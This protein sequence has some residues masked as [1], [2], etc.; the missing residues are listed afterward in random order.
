MTGDVGRMT[1]R[2]ALVGTMAMAAGLAGGAVAQAAPRGPVDPPVPGQ[3]PKNAAAPAVVTESTSTLPPLAKGEQAYSVFNADLS[4]SS[5]SAG[6]SIVYVASLAGS[7]VGPGSG[8]L[9]MTC[10]VPVGSLITAVDCSLNGNPRGGSSVFC[11]EH[12]PGGDGFVGTVDSKSFTAGAGVETQTLTINR[13]YTGVEAFEIYFGGLSATSV[14][15]GIRVRYFPPASGLV[16][17]NTV[18][19]YDSVTASVGTNPV[20]VI[21]GGTHGIPS[22]AT[23]VAVNVAVSHPTSDGYVRVTPY[24]HDAPVALQQFKAGQVISNAT[25]VKLN[26]RRLQVKVSAGHARIVMDVYGYFTN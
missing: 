11:D 10:N 26:V 21:V 18:R 19:V 2:S 22:N 25:V 9:G 13:R 12:H 16:P 14:A 3:S 4:P 17:I 8:W 6:A 23:A 1:R 15:R 20:P 5:G 7:Y 24:A